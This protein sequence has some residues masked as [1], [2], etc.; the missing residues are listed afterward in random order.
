MNDEKRALL[1]GQGWSDELID[2]F[3]KEDEQLTW[4][5]PYRIDDPPT[6][7]LSEGTDLRADA[8]SSLLLTSGETLQLDD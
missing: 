1:K 5:E 3:L 2:A 7:T 8:S 6:T 4:A